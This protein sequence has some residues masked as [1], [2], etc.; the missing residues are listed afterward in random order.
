MGMS[1]SLSKIENTLGQQCDT[2]PHANAACWVP[3]LVPAGTILIH[4]QHKS[5]NVRN[6][7]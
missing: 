4:F 3:P 1:N 2:R 5:T 6:K 7:R